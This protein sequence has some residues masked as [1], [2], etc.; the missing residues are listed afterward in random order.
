MH[1]CS[2]EG[3]LPELI[4]EGLEII[5][6]GGFG[7]FVSIHFLYHPSH[8]PKTCVGESLAI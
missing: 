7:P 6:L 2:E 3:Y 5:E 1:V 8:D 4:L